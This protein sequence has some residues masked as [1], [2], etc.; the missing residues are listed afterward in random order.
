MKI[1]YLVDSVRD[2]A[3]FLLYLGLAKEIGVDNVDIEPLIRAYVSGEV[4]LTLTYAWMN[5]AVLALAGT[6]GPIGE[7]WAAGYDLIVSSVGVDAIKALDGVVAKNGR[8]AINKLAFIDLAEGVGSEGL[9]FDLVD[10][11]APNVY[12]KASPPSFVWKDEERLGDKL[13][14]VPL[15]IHGIASATA[16]DVPRMFAHGRSRARQLLAAVGLPIGRL[17]ADS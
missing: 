3:A 14:R 4:K 2:A 1:L 10:R 9:K 7:P 11:F 17:A 13:V 8:W 12:C 5:A 6:K 15:V 16:E